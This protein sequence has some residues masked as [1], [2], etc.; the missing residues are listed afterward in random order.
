MKRIICL[1]LCLLT[2]LGAAAGEE[3]CPPREYEFTH[4]AVRSYDSETLKYRLESF[5]VKRVRCYLVKLWMQDPGKQIKKATAG[6]QEKT[7]LPKEMADSIPEAI[8]AINGSGYW[9]PQ[10]PDVPAE[11]PGDVSD[12]YYTPWGSLTVTDGE[13]FRNLPEI[14]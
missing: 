5:V 1:L 8:L 9:S 2:L 3:I 13:V 6:W 7:M 14:P 10:Y 11:Y 4:K 12:Y